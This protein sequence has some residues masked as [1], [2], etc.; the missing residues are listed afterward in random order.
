MVIKQSLICLWVD[1][2]NLNIRFIKYLISLYQ[3]IYEKFC[4][5]NDEK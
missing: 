2:K 4:R 3:S 5:K 1:K